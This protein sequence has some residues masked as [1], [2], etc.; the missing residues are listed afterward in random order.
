MTSHICVICICETVA[1]CWCNSV[2][3]VSKFSKATIVRRLRL[4]CK[5]T[6][7]RRL[8]CGLL[9]VSFVKRTVQCAVFIEDL[10]GKSTRLLTFEN[11]GFVEVLY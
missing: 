3:K 7:M 5:A 11:F 1:C 4:P 6:I 2:H 9:L 8:L 10:Q